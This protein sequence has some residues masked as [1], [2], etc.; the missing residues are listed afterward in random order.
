MKAN[1]FLF[2]FLG[3]LDESSFSQL[4]ILYINNIE[5]VT[6]NKNPKYSPNSKSDIDKKTYEETNNIKDDFFLRDNK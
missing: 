6:Y 3:L 4:I 2:I 1:D 5:I